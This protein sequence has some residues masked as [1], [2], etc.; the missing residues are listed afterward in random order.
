MR[1]ITCLIAILLG[2]LAASRSLPL[3][4]PGTESEPLK[5]VTGGDPEQDKAYAVKQW[6]LG[7]AA[8][9]TERNYDSHTLLA[10]RPLTEQG[11]LAAQKL[12]SGA[13]DVNN[14]VELL[15]TLACLRDE[16][17]RADFEEIGESI[18]PLPP[19]IYKYLLSSAN[20]PEVINKLRIVREYYAS[21]GDKSL[22]GW[23]YSRAICLCRWGYTVGYLSEEEA[24]GWI[25]PLARLLQERFDSWEDLGENYLIGRR[26]WSY[27]ETKKE[28]WRYEDAV[29]R[30]LDMRD[31]PWNRYPWDLDLSEGDDSPSDN[32][33]DWPDAVVAS[34]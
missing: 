23:D 19:Q 13:W 34:R 22:C 1:T 33:S 27:Q 14:R 29:Q 32:P 7:C 10:G 20:E 30:L 16:G 18:E 12:L 6:A 28:G 26:F 17:H 24:W 4:A 11:K 2:S 31:S 8:V 3:D 25:L 15:E 21:L 5:T 9:L